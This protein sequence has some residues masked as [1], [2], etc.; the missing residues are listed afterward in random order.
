LRPGSGGL[1]SKRSPH[2]ALPRAE[3]P[4]KHD[5]LAGVIGVVVCDE[6]GF[7]QQVLALAPCKRFHKGSRCGVPEQLFKVLTVLLDLVDGVVPCTRVWR[8]RSVWPVRRRPLSGFVRAILIPAEVED[9]ALRDADMLNDLPGGVRIT[10]PTPPGRSLSISASRS[11][12]GMSW[13]AAS[14]VA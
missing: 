5:Q 13:T 3:Q 8:F 11:E 2:L 6:Q 10:F 12:A 4:P 9:I 1:R 7:A 14:K